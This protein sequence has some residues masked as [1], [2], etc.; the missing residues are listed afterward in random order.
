MNEAGVNSS[1][2]LK[3]EAFVKV[4]NMLECDDLAVID[5]LWNMIELNN[6]VLQT[7]VHRAFIAICGI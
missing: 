4:L 2:S 6:E 1:E 3:P 5:Q 7:N